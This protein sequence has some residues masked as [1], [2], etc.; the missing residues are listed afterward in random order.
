MPNSAKGTWGDFIDDESDKTLYQVIDSE[1]Q[2]LWVRVGPVF[3]DDSDEVDKT[4]GIW[5][6]YQEKSMGA[7]LQGPILMSPEIWKKLKDFVDT[8]IK[9]FSPGSYKALPGEGEPAPSQ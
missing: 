9:E 6:N 7:K 8:N 1:E 2:V 4:P 3:V 5:I